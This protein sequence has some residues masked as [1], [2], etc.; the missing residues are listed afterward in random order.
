MP[1][2]NELKAAIAAEAE[3]KGVDVPETE[4]K[5][6]AE[7]ASILKDLKAPP[8]PA[9]AENKDADEADPMAGAQ[10]AADVKAETQAK[11]ENVEIKRPPF[12]IA[13]NKSITSKK[14][15]L[16]EGDEV[17]AEYLGGGK[18]SL[19]AHIKAGNVLKG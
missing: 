3:A 1:S 8:A 2:N 9:P 14:G 16:N 13:E 15:T 19:D 12:Y 11:K 7:L 18:Q 10:N 4:G 6:N 17:K 5:N